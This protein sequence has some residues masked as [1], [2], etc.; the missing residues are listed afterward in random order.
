MILI[1][2]KFFL[3][4]TDYDESRAQQPR[5]ADLGPVFVGSF[6]QR[7]PVRGTLRE[8]PDGLQMDFTPKSLEIDLDIHAEL[9]PKLEEFRKSEFYLKNPIEIYINL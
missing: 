2:E 1:I 7:F 3:K 5:S 8:D 6:F 4:D 9:A